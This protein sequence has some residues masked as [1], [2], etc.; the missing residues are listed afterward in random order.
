MK[1]ELKQLVK[2]PQ[3]SVSCMEETI[4]IALILFPL[5]GRGK[6]DIAFISTSEQ[7]PKDNALHTKAWWTV[8]CHI[9]DDSGSK[10]WPH[11]KELS[12]YPS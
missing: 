8:E 11:Q 9:S 7:S 6:I 2:M 5:D 10:A 12:S 4:A 3:L 1:C